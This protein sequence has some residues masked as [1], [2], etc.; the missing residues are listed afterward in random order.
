MPSKSNAF[1]QSFQIKDKYQS[2]KSCV[3]V[4]DNY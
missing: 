3:V 2:G 1:T 4:M